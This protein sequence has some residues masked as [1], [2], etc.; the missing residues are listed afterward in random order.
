LI[1]FGTA[2]ARLAPG[3]NEPVTEG[4]WPCRT[5]SRLVFVEFVSFVL[6][7]PFVVGQR[8]DVMRA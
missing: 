7:V 8:S 5:K 2:P 6:F 4:R 3:L 1:G